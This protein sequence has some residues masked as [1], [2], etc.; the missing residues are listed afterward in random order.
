MGETVKN[1]GVHGCNKRGYATFVRADRFAR[2]T[3]RWRNAK[4][5]AYRCLVCHQF[6]VGE[7]AD[8]NRKLGKVKAMKR[9]ERERRAEERQDIEDA[10]LRFEEPPVA[11]IPPSLARDAEHIKWLREQDLDIVVQ[12]EVGGPLI[13]L[14]K[15]LENA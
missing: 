2:D 1:N 11:V 7:R 4:V 10:Q 15:W 3:R 12:T 5:E 8:G 9:I 14:E 6:H 13:P